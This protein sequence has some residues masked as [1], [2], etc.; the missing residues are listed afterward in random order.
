MMNEKVPLVLTRTF[1]RRL[2]DAKVLI[3][4]ANETS[5]EGR[6]EVIGDA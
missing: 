6:R 1:K 2:Y 5:L 3:K 4:V